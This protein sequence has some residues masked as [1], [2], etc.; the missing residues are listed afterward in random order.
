[1][2]ER[3][4]AGR[5][6]SVPSLMYVVEKLKDGSR[7][8]RILPVS[9]AP[10]ARMAS[11]SITSTGARV[12]VEV[13]PLTRVPVTVTASSSFAARVKS[14]FMVAPADTRTFWVTLP[15]PLSSADTT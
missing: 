12:S 1:M 6:M 14:A 9:L 10:V 11:P 8:C 3:S 4:V 2:S 5:M 7:S 13:R 15:K